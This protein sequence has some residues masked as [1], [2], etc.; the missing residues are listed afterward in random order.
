MKL[1]RDRWRQIFL[2]RR[3]WPSTCALPQ[4]KL[5][6]FFFNL[7][8]RTPSL[9]HTWCFVHSF[10]FS[11]GLVFISL[12]VRVRPSVHLALLRVLRT[13]NIL[14]HP[15]EV[16]LAN[17]ILLAS[18]IFFGGDILNF[19]F[20]E[21]IMLTRFGN[22]Y[23]FCTPDRLVSFVAFFCRSTFQVLSLILTKSAAACAISPRCPWWFINKYW[24]G[25]PVCFTLF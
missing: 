22:R 2:Y 19:D 8:L 10:D 25:S 20:S 14:N 13:A 7:R 3:F 16:L 17:R 5:R 6:P 12:M 15:G 11:F 1:L 21:I 23:A 4:Y 9:L 18:L 24:S